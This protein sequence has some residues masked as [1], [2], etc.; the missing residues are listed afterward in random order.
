MDIL[1]GV[2]FTA[3]LFAIGLMGLDYFVFP[4]GQPKPEN[5]QDG[6]MFYCQHCNSMGLHTLVPAEVGVLFVCIDCKGVTV[7]D[8]VDPN[9]HVAFFSPSQPD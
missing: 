1:I 9:V 3:L 2:F 6:Y 5:I 8:A 4:K 7:A